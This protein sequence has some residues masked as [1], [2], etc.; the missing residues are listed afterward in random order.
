MRPMIA[1]RRSPALLVALVAVVAAV[2]GTDY[3]FGGRPAGFASQVQGLRTVSKKTASGTTPSKQVTARCPHGL[4][5]LGGGAR[6][7]VTPPSSGKSL[8]IALEENTPT[9]DGAK[10]R[11]GWLARAGAGPIASNTNWS[12]EATAIC[13]R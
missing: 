13:G 10:Q 12:L 9:P 5:V 1:R 11:T 4:K 8:G 6:I 3:A 2:A 7:V